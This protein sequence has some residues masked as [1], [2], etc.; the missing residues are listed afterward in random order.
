MYHY[1]NE[2]ILDNFIQWNTNQSLL[3]KSI[4]PNNMYYMMPF[5]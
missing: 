4:T 3:D 5:I 1:E 2:V